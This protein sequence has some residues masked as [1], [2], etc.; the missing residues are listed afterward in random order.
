[1]RSVYEAHTKN[2]L[3]VELKPDLTLGMSLSDR[4]ILK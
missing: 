1:M 3:K 4:E 2:V